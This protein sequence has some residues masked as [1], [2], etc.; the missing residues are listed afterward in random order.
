MRKEYR[1]NNFRI[2]GET[3]DK[4]LERLRKERFHSADRFI[5]NMRASMDSNKLDD[6][7]KTQ[8]EILKKMLYDKIM[9]LPEFSKV[10]FLNY[11]KELMLTNQMIKAG[12]DSDEIGK[13]I[14]KEFGGYV[15]VER[16]C[17]AVE[18]GICGFCGNKLDKPGK[19]GKPV[20]WYNLYCCREHDLEWNE[21]RDGLDHAY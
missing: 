8:K 9:T 17:E 7:N 20:E 18:K 1:Q 16:R 11:R 15:W 10:T 12:K 3:A 14:K 5:K 2:T 13:E 21:I 6:T 4:Y 19:L